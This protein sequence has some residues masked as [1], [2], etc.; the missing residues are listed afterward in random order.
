[1]TDSISL[2]SYNPVLG[3]HYRCSYKY[4]NDTEGYYIAEQ[5]EQGEGELKESGLFY[6]RFLVQ[7]KYSLPSPSH[8]RLLLL[9]TRQQ[10]ADLRRA[11][12]KE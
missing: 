7:M 10:S 5:G 11:Q 9:L 8:Q 6:W 1:M 3:E 2:S 12:T 4:P